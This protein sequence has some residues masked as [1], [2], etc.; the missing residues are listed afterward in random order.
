MLTYILMLAKIIEI[1]KESEKNMA[2][3]YVINDRNYV[4]LRM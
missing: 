2:R 4:T 1:K 3:T